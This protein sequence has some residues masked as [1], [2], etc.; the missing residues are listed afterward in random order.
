MFFTS[1]FVEV[2]LREVHSD[3]WVIES[4]CQCRYPTSSDRQRTSRTRPPAMERS[5]LHS[6]RATPGDRGLDTDL[7]PVRDALNVA[8]GAELGQY[9]PQR[10]VKGAGSG[11]TDR[12]AGEA[13]LRVPALQVLCNSRLPQVRSKAACAS[14]RKEPAILQL[15]Q[16]VHVLPHS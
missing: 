5:R 4:S 1:H 8:A 3:L 2:N 15:A 12:G 9:L 16:E 10:G 11:L 14:E 13:A 6:S 7:Q